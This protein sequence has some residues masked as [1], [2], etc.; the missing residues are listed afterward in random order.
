[1]NNVCWYANVNL[2][3]LSKK[4]TLSQKPLYVMIES[5]A[6]HLIGTPSA[7]VKIK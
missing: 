1:M 7:Y 4:P 3:G 6:V 5:N 2:I